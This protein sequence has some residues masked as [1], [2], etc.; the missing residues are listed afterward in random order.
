MLQNDCWGN[1]ICL[2]LNSEHSSPMID[3]VKFGISGS[4]DK[5]LANWMSVRLLMSRVHRRGR[6]QTS[7]RWSRPTPV[8]EASDSVQVC[9]HKSPRLFYGQMALHM[10]PYSE[11]RGSTSSR[12]VVSA[13]EQ[14]ADVLPMLRHHALSASRLAQNAARSGS[15]P[16]EPSFII[17]RVCHVPSFR[18]CQERIL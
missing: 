15:S 17:C 16:A 18:F 8:N 9:K 14:G 13:I 11:Q 6:W 7:Q 5:H 1:I 4:R 12:L 10:R 2:H 3:R